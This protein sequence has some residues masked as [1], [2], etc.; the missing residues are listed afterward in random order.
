M[1]K[2]SGLSMHSND[3]RDHERS[4]DLVYREKRRGPRTEP[5]GTPLVRVYGAD[6]TPR[7]L[8]GTTTVVVPSVARQTDLTVTASWETTARVSTL[9]STL[10]GRIK[11]AH[12]MAV[13]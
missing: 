7:P 10:T 13:F 8:V 2:S 12:P 4:S 9:Y 1:W 3:R 11:C 5:W 6:S